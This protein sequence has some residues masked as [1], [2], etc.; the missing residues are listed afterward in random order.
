MCNTD[1]VVFDVP[2][3]AAG[4]IVTY[5]VRQPSPL[6]VQYNTVTYSPSHCPASLLAF[7]INPV[8]IGA[9]SLTLDD[10]ARTITISGMD[11][12]EANKSSTVSLTVEATMYDSALA[13]PPSQTVTFS[14][15]TI[16]NCVDS[17]PRFEPAL[18]DMHGLAGGLAGTQTM[19]LTDSYSESIGT[20]GYCGT[21]EYDTS[22][23]DLTILELDRA[24]YTFTLL[25]PAS[26]SYPP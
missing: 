2:E 4:N 5:D 7:A 10:I 20:P 8:S 14:L 9:I 21:L 1:S 22:A 23:D 6:V 24:T 26:W 18:N 19:T 13:S 25:V 11:L 16:D 3:F 17:I 15:Q 12:A